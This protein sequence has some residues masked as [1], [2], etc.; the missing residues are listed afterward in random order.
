MGVIPEIE[1]LIHD[2]FNHG[3]STLLLEELTSASSRAVTLS[4]TEP[5]C[6]AHFMDIV[7]LAVKD[8]L[9]AP[10]KQSFMDKLKQFGEDS[11]MNL[12]KCNVTVQA[13][14]NPFL[15]EVKELVQKFPFN[16]IL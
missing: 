12:E 4:T 10:G 6:P 8:L 9:L 11:L 14:L 7:R 2:I 16:L 15:G 5:S 13:F 3:N 1:K